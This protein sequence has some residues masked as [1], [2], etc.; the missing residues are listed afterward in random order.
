MKLTTTFA[1]LLPLV[2]KAAAA[3]AA[4][5]S[6]SSS[7]H[8]YPAPPPG[9]DLSN[10]TVT[11]IGTHSYDDI[12][13]DSIVNT[14]DHESG[15]EKRQGTGVCGPLS[16]REIYSEDITALRWWLQ[17]N[18]PHET[19]PLPRRS[20]TGWTMGTAM[21]CIYNDYHFQ[22]TAVARR[23]MGWLTGHIQDICNFHWFTWNRGGWQPSAGRGVDGLLVRSA[24]ISPLDGC[25]R[26]RA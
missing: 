18:G 13:T 9:L 6:E 8:D 7:P 20:F 10:I 5:A 21:I 23:E 4:A 1:I 24:V 2:L 25:W 14:T 11:W 16:S 12:P 17:Q 26:Y 3:P 15:L 22:D 19:L